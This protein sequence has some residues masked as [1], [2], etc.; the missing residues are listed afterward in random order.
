M[1]QIC[2][3][4]GT[5]NLPVSKCIFAQCATNADC[6]REVGGECIAFFD[7]CSRVNPFANPG[8]AC[9]YPSTACRE[10][11]DCPS[12]TPACMVHWQHLEEGLGC[13]YPDCAG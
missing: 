5:W 10:H 3:P 4:G 13:Y 6:S 7:L 12:E 8:K 9:H 1:D 11:S 2:V